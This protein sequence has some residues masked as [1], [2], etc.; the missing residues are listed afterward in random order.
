M[1]RLRTAAVP[2]LFAKRRAKKSEA[3]TMH[4]PVPRYW[5]GITTEKQSPLLT[6][7]EL[8]R[9]KGIPYSRQHLK[10]LENAGQFPRRIR[11]SV[12]RIG[13]LEVEVDRWVSTKADAR[14]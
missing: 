6:Y 8:K 7:P 5:S 10:R 3:Q 1:P 2:K 14:V 13:W 12:A 11:I 9:L 4:P